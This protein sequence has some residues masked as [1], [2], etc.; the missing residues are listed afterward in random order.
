[1]GSCVYELHVF[2]GLCVCVCVCVVV[3]IV[4]VVRCLWVRVLG[5]WFV[6][7]WMFVC[8]IDYICGFLCV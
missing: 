4:Y 6:F 7:A 8:M 1:V 5:F 2:C 3:V